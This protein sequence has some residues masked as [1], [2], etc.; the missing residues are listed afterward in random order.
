[1]WILGCEFGNRPMLFNYAISIGLQHTWYLKPKRLKLSLKPQCFACHAAQATQYST[2]QLQCSLIVRAA[3][4]EKLQ[5]VNNL[6]VVLMII[7][8][9]SFL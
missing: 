2:V 4:H 9:Y 1:M 7:Y 5:A 3:I 8:I 6:E